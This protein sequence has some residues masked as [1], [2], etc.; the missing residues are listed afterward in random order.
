MP[1]FIFNHNDDEL[2]VN[3]ALYFSSF[4]DRLYYFSTI[5]SQWINST[6]HIKGGK[7]RGKV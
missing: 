7:A 4:L 6:L 5:L 1:Y 3:W 2:M